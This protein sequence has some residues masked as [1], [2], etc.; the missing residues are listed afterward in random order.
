MCHLQLLHN[1]S[2][3]T[4]DNKYNQIVSIASLLVSIALFCLAVSFCC[5]V[6]SKKKRNIIPIVV[7]ITHY[8]YDNIRNFDLLYNNPCESSDLLC[9]ICLENN[10]LEIVSLDCNHNFHKHCINNWFTKSILEDKQLECPI[11]RKVF[12]SV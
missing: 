1:N 5:M 11:C 2:A 8:M 3:T 6:C 10:S 7:E 9:T 4:Q 12:N